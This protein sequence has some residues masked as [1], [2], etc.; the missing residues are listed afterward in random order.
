MAP[1]QLSRFSLHGNWMSA[2][3]L[4]RCLAAVLLAVLGAVTP[5]PGQDYWTGEG[6]DNRWDNADNWASGIVPD[7]GEV[8][9]NGPEAEGTAGPLIEDGIDAVAGVLIADA[10]EPVM[11]MTGGSLELNGWGTW[12]SD[13]PGTIANFNMSG[14]VVEFT[15]S[16]GIMEVGWQDAGDPPGSSVGIWTMTGGEV[17]AKG[18]D[19]PGKNNGGIGIINLWGGMF[20]VGLE[21]GGLVLYE[22][23]QLD[24]TEGVL[25]LEGDQS[26]I[27]RR[28][29]RRRMDDRL[30]RRWRI[31]HGVRR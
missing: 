12:W 4:A 8:R 19:M 31:D 13:A 26:A 15:G 17:I 2:K 10:G 23:A 14:G 20:N 6:A 3:Q 22:G 25:V 28:L 5:A 24:I 16:P 1:Q 29:Y 11:T 21:R 18:V 30:R 9:V 7:F 27:G